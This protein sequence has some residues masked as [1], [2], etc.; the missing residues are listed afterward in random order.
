MIAEVLAPLI[1]S[2]ICQIYFPIPKPRITLSN[3]TATIFKIGHKKSFTVKDVCLG[4]LSL[5]LLPGSNCFTHDKN[6]S[7]TG[8]WSASQI[9]DRW[10]FW[11]LIYYEAS[12][13]FLEQ[14][15]SSLL[16]KRTY[17]SDSWKRTWRWAQHFPQNKYTEWP[18][19]SEVIW[20]Y[21]MAHNPPI[22]FLMSGVPS[23]N[24][25]ICWNWDITKHDS[26]LQYNVECFESDVR[27][28][29]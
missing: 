28:L 27:Q 23:H 13:I 22:D 26:Y 17:P 24:K 6:P 19:G 3:A 7:I 20:S 8:F 15:A 1:V 21:T 16:Y 18:G 2:I 9:A 5:P 4:F 14:Q 12:G 11:L 25:D 29:H 10:Y